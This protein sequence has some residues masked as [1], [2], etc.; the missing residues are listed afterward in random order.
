MPYGDGTGPEGYGPIT[1]RG[2]GFC[3]GYNSPGFNKG[4]PRGGRGR[5]WKG[6]G[7]RGGFG[8]KFNPRPGMGARFTHYHPR[9]LSPPRYNVDRNIPYERMT[10]PVR[11]EYSEEEEREDLKA[12]AE[13]LKNE[14]EA[15]ENRIEEL[16][17]QE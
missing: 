13:E 16:E 1:G 8:R 11:Y 12:Y 5:R 14:L 4:V 2:L 7:F 10:T 3:T 6:R 17:N 9:E 15:I